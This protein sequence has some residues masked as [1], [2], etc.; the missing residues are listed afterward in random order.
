MSK[1]KNPFTKVKH[2]Q[3]SGCD[4]SDMSDYMLSA[5]L[6][7]K[8]SFMERCWMQISVIDTPARMLG[9]LGCW[10]TNTR[11]L[12]LTVFLVIVR[13]NT[14]GSMAC[15]I[16]E[17]CSNGFAA[18]VCS[19]AAEFGRN[20]SP[21]LCEIVLRVQSTHQEKNTLLGGGR[22]ALISKQQRWIRRHS[23]FEGS[24]GQMW[25]TKH[26]VIRCRSIIMVSLRSEHPQKVKSLL[27]LF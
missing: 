4:I 9:G 13:A 21:Q 22:G 15:V 12:F 24:T 8:V 26:T 1:G 14:R 17:F 5:Y 18:P 23:W 16:V 11:W 10:L 19:E 25:G 7:V 2:C 3:F 6:K 20:E 27:G